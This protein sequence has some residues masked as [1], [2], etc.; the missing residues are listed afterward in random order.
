MHVFC[1]AC[2]G[3]LNQSPDTRLCAHQGLIFEKGICVD[4]LVSKEELVEVLRQAGFHE[5]R[6]VSRALEQ[7]VYSQGSQIA[8]EGSH[9]IEQHIFPVTVEIIR[10]LAE[11]GRLEPEVVATALLHDVLENDRGVDESQFRETFGARVYSNVKQLTK[12]D[13]MSLPGE[14]EADKK[15]Y[16]DKQYL[17]S[18]E[19]APWEVIVVKLADRL[20][21]IHRL[22]SSPR[23]H[24]LVLARA[25]YVHETREYILPLAEKHS[26]YFYGKIFEALEKSET[27]IRV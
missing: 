17:E 15:A 7:V 9:Q 13:W 21:N 14:S 25:G 8:D 6:L 10:F 19:N 12:H 3:E 23:V 27:N 20:N 18:L 26:P 2:F 11:Q 16:R 22:N 24:H 1:D 4:V 5:N